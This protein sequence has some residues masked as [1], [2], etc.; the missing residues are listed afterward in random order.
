MS[1]LLCKF[2]SSLGPGGTAVL[3]GAIP[4]G[5]KLEIEARGFL[6]GERSITGSMMGS[7]RFKLDVPYFL[8]LYRPRRLDLDSM[9]ISPRPL[10]EL[11]HALPGL[12]GGAALTPVYPLYE[13]WFPTGAV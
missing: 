12:A 2:F 9:T 5:E 3:V 11:N 1:D 7:N 4:A 8:D 10:A 6:G 13:V